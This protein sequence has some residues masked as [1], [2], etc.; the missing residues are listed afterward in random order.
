MGKFVLNNITTC[1]PGQICH[2]TGDHGPN[3]PYT[4]P[5]SKNTNLKQVSPGLHDRTQKTARTNIKCWKMICPTCAHLPEQVLR[6]VRNCSHVLENI[7][8][9]LVSF[10]CNVLYQWRNWR[11]QRG[12]SPSLEVKCKN[13]ALAS[14]IFRFF[15][16]F[17]VFS[18]DLGFSI[19]I[20]IDPDSSFL[21]FFLSVG[22]RAA[23]EA[24]GPLSATFPPWVKPLV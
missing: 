22:K 3:W 5:R 6:R 10:S 12:E 7:S 24:N 15:A 8:P 19:A 2:T 23:T 21:N 18:S 1:I 11:G 9:R 20:H 17:G 13:R 4:H 16:F 14:L